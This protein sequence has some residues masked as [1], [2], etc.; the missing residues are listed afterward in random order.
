MR[1]QAAAG[2]AAARPCLL[3]PLLVALL[4]GCPAATSALRWLPT[5]A[6]QAQ[7]EADAEEVLAAG[8]AAGQQ[9]TPAVE[10]AVVGSAVLGEDGSLAFVS[11]EVPGAAPP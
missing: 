6:A 11:G 5:S 4:C 7:S 1:A 9:C 2:S 3:L 8:A 10:G